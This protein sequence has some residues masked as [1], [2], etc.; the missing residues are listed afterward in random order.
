MIWG[1]KDILQKLFQTDF[2]NPEEK[3]ASNL[4]CVPT[5]PGRQEE[6]WSGRSTAHC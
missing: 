1:E 3:Y 4:G 2:I 6:A 5:G